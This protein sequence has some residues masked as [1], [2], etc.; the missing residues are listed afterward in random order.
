MLLAMILLAIAT[1]LVLD[2]ARQPAPYR[3][4]TES[5]LA[6]CVA[7]RKIG[8]RVAKAPTYGAAK[9]RLRALRALGWSR[10]ARIWAA[11]QILGRYFPGTHRHLI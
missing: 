3:P 4:P 1:L 2:A 8:V 7:A 5:P 9:A 11:H 6:L 10:E